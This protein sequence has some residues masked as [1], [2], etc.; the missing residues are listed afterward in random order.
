[1][2]ISELY[3]S[4]SSSAE[5]VLLPASIIEHIYVFTVTACKVVTEDCKSL[6]LFQAGFVSAP[7]EV[8]TNE[9]GTVKGMKKNSSSRVDLDAGY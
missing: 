8:E 9:R 1:M 3:L 4:R 7:L 2:Q 6:F 5:A